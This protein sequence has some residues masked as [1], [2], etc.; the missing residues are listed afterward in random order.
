MQGDFI[1]G[2]DDQGQAGVAHSNFEGPDRQAGLGIAGH[3][4]EVAT[5]GLLEAEVAADQNEV[6]DLCQEAGDADRHCAI[7]DDE[8]GGDAADIQR[9][10]L[11]HAR[12]VVSDGHA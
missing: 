11:I 4:G 7:G 2:V 5:R 6:C 9:L 1:R 8:R 12:V 10:V 3:D